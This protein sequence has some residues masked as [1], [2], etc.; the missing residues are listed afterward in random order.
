LMPMV[1]RALMGEHLTV[2]RQEIAA[3]VARN[4]RFF[5]AGCRHGG[6]VD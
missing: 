5:L 3:H 4:V 1:F 2:L 6:I